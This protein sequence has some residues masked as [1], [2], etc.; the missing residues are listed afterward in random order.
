ML[1]NH[2]SRP[3][4]S[5]HGIE[6]RGEAV[7]QGE[8]TLYLIVEASDEAR[9]RE[10]MQPLQMVG[11]LDISP[12]STCAGVVARGGYGAALTSESVPAL[13]PEQACQQAIEA[14]LVVHRAHPL[15]RSM[16]RPRFPIC[17]V[18]SSCRTLTSTSGITSKFL[19]LSRRPSALA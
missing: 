16:V 2:L 14:G 18:V 8:H 5:Q 4:V 10:F 15:T 3:N 6:I 12:A 13:D 9:L 19:P 17:S 1:L 11:S 7:V